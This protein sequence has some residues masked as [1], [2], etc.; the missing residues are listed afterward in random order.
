[1]IKIFRDNLFFFFFVIRNIIILFVTGHGPLDSN[2]FEYVNTLCV[3]CVVILR[4]SYKKNFV[5]KITKLDQELFTAC[6]LK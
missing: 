5:L 6:Y 1:M 3:S 4:Q 2:R